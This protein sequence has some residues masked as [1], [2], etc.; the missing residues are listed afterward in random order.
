MQE[1]N[2]AGGGGSNAGVSTGALPMPK[3]V[4]VTFYVEPEQLAAVRQ[5]LEDN[6]VYIRNVGPDYIEALVPPALLPAASERPGVRRVDTVIP[7]ESYQS[8]GREVSQGVALHHADVWHRMGYRGQGVKV[9]IIDSGFEGFSQRQGSE[10]PR[11]VMARCYP[12]R[13]STALVSSSLADCEVRTVHGTAVAETVIDVA[14]GVELYISNARS[15]GDVR[16]AVDWMVENNVAVINRSTGVPYHGPGDGTSWQS[17]GV[18]NSVDAAVSGGIVFVQAAGNATNKTWY[19]AFYDPDGNNWHNYTSDDESNHFYLEFDEDDPEGVTAFMRWDDTSGG[20]DC[21]LNLYLARPGPDGLTNV[22]VDTVV[23]D[24]EVGDIPYAIVRFVADSAEDEGNYHLF[25][26]KKACADEPAWMQLMAFMDGDVLQY[27]SPG[28][29]IDSAAE[30]RNQGMLAVGAAHWASPQ[31]IASY[32]SR[33]PTPDGQIK[34]DIT[35]IACGRSTVYSPRAR[36]GTECWFPGT[37]Q[38]A[39]HVAGLAALVKQRFPDYTP[40]QVTAYLKKHADDHERGPLGADNTWGYGLAVLPPGPEPTLRG[41]EP[42]TDFEVRP[43]ENSDEVVISWVPVP[44]AT[45][46]RIGYVN[47]EVDFHLATRASCTMERD[48][49]L[50]AF[51]YVDV[52]APNVPVRD[53]RAEYT[54]RRLSEGARHAFTVLSS[55]NLYNNSLNVGAEFSW[56]KLGPQKLRWVR[57]AGRSDLPPGIPIPSLDCPQ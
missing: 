55:N 28:H 45:H 29:H 13:G 5:Y 19:G 22:D 51:V 8:S 49:W 53:G 16:T 42:I 10:L 18:L 34:P 6:D 40:E 36:D 4:L 3:P 25:I 47:L 15:L 9:G 33:G 37:S 31:A 46:Y 30:S 54:I 32:S 39:P 21:D 56:P 7:P 27:Y 41:S 20:A 44:E 2:S 17:D 11:S 48:D 57:V 24:G 12:P 26:Q 1:N 52:K 23:Q 38:A 14:P 43:G 35:G 50:Q